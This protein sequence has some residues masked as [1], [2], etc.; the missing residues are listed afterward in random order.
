[1]LSCLCL[2][3]LHSPSGKGLISG[4]PVCDVSCV[5]VTF[6]YGILGQVWCLIVS[7]PNRCP[8]P[9]FH[10]LSL[11]RILLRFEDNASVYMVV[12]THLRIS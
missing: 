12:Y 8:L 6:P 3:P 2:A 5:F 9:Y 1:M 10:N 11:W 7:I 4:S